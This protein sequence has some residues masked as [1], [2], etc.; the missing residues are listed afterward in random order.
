[1]SSQLA[2]RNDEELSYFASGLLEGR[3][4]KIMAYDLI[5][6]SVDERAFHKLSVTAARELAR[7]LNA[8]AD[9]AEQTSLTE[10]QLTVQT[11]PLG[12]TDV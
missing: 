2:T 1:M 8:A 11:L 4:V 12:G 3:E 6:L 9:A 10:N 5:I 7:H